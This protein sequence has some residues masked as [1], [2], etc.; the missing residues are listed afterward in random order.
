MVTVRSYRDEDFGDLVR[1]FDETWGWELKGS[2]EEN[3]DLASMYI[4]LALVAADTVYVCEVDGSVQ[5]VTCLQTSMK[6]AL[7]RLDNKDYDAKTYF[8]MAQ[9]LENKLQQTESGRFAL[10]FYERLDAVNEILIEKLSENGVAWDVELKLLLTSPSCRGKGVGKALVTKV[11]DELRSK[12]V[13]TCMLRTDTHCA[14][15]YYE[16]TGWTRGAEYVW[17]DEDDLTALAY[18]KAVS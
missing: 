16:K 3:L 5:G 15:E 14:W 4:A 8:F 12:A 7:E 17:P 1:M 6:S 9:T 10:D 18:V 11:F 13:K 2:S